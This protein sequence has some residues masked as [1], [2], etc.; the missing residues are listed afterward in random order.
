MAGK[1]VRYADDS[2]QRMLAGVNV[3]VNAVKV[4]LG[5]KVRNVVLKRR[6]Q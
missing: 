3:L 6:V 2:R 4:T 5:P 1:E